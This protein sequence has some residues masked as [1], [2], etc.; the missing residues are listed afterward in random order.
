[1]TAGSPPRYRLRST[2]V[3]VLGGLASA[4]A[5]ACAVTAASWALQTNRFVYDL[6]GGPPGAIW[7]VVFWS[8][9]LT[10]YVLCGMVLVGWPVLAAIRKWRPAW[11]GPKLIYALGVL[12]GSV[13]VGIHDLPAIMAFKDGGDVP[14]LSLW[15]ALAFTV[16]AGAALGLPA[17]VIF[18]LIALRREAA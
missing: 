6:N 15:M 16:A 18:R 1:M 13:G 2:P 9:F 8:L 5:G 17:V 14:Q 10:P 3:V 7:G 4:Y 12:A 11:L